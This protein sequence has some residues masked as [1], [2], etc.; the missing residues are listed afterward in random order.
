MSEN[1]PSGEQRIHNFIAGAQAAS[2]KTIEQYAEAE[3]IRLIQDRLWS[4]YNETSLQQYRDIW[5]KALW[6]L[7]DK[8]MDDYEVGA[9]YW[10]F[11][12]LIERDNTQALVTTQIQLG[13]PD[14]E[15]T[16]ETVGIRLVM[17][18]KEKRWESTSIPQT[19]HGIKVQGRFVNQPKAR[20]KL[21][22]QTQETFLRDAQKIRASVTVQALGHD[23]EPT[24]LIDTSVWRYNI[25]AEDGTR[26]RTFL[27]G[28]APELYRYAKR[29]AETRGLGAIDEQYVID[30]LTHELASHDARI[31]PAFLMLHEVNDI[32][33]QSY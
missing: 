20:A 14:W 23:Q 26:I 32:L 25:D 1:F 7:S 27:P 16:D 19:I 6:R 21:L 12:S 2:R 10:N 4:Q 9:A 15:T 5:D 31:R 28:I 13:L 22:S 3:P 24:Q 29:D 18:R 8:P 17:D 33:D 11:E 30:W